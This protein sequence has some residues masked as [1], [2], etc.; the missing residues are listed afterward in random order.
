MRFLDLFKTQRDIVKEEIVEVPWHVLGTLDQLDTIIEESKEMP[1]A[2][3]KHSTRCGI[4]RGVLKIFERN[5]KYTDD[6]VK[7]YFLDLLQNR[8][9]SNE[10]ANRFKV[11]HES[12]QLLII[13]NGVVVYHNSH[14]AIEA[15][16]IEEY[17]K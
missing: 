4:S 3:F 16:Q 1:V 17:L 7:L 15:S 11:R 8:D 5:Y 9:V 2:I 14:H 12:P 10:I 13:K 6:Q